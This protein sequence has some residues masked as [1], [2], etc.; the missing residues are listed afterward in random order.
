MFCHSHKLSTAFVTYNP[1]S[2]LRKGEKK[3]IP[4]FNQ[5]LRVHLNIHVCALYLNK[6][7]MC[8]INENV[9]AVDNFFEMLNTLMSGLI[10]AIRK[11]N[12]WIARGFAWE[13]LRSCTGYGPGR[14]VKRHG[15]SC[16]LHLKKNFWLGVRVFCE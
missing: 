8:K 14:S 5:K 2:E 1:W 9:N 16:S 7:S 11:K 6:Y 4:I 13:Y 10:Q 15:K 3:C 12:S